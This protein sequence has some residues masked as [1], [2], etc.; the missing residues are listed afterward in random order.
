L[1]LLERIINTSS[2]E[3]DIVLDAFCGC[4]TALVAAQK[5]KRQWIGID[6]SPTAC[7]VMAK[8]LK[9]DCGLKED[10]KLWQIGRG[11]IV[12]DFPKTEEELRKYPPFEFENRAVV[13][14]GGTKNARQVGDMGIDGRIYPI[15]AMP[16]RRGARTGEMDFMDEWYPIQVKQTDKVGRPDID[17]FETAMQRAERKLGYFVGFELP[18]MRF[19]KSIDFVAR[20]VARSSR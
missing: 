19:S 3:N 16:E 15:S 11:V 10:E 7:R 17:A 13:A 12:R 20:K 9:K 18:A 2:K 5:L 14:L 4:G 8:P 1:P 6:I